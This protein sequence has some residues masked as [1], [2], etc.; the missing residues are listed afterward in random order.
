VRRSK[1]VAKEISATA[2]E[3]LILIGEKLREGY[4]GK[5]EIDCHDG[6]VR[7]LTIPLR[8]SG[9]ELIDR[10]SSQQKGGQ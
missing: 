9:K 10:R 2:R 4:S 7:N 6:G 8:Y 5:I 1:I 3:A